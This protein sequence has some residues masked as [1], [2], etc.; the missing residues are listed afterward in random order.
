M[1]LDALLERYGPRLR[2]PTEEQVQARESLHHR[3]RVTDDYLRVYLSGALSLDL[4][5]DLR[6][7]PASNG[8]VP[9]WVGDVAAWGLAE[10]VDVD[11]EMPAVL[12]SVFYRVGETY[13]GSWLVQISR[14]GHRGKLAII[15]DYAL[16]S[17]EA[18]EC[19]VPDEP[20]ADDE[21]ADAYLAELE[22]QNVLQIHD[23]TLEQFIELRVT[24][25]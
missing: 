13:G 15:P 23:L 10:P 9:A 18:K 21:A 8:D 17:F 7:D 3:L 4:A 11:D 16:A 19:A 6:V 20:I 12:S 14:G 1:P 2:V 24:H 5:K 25:A 22:E